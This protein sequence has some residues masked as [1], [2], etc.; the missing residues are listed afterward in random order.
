MWNYL[1]T[2]IFIG[3]LTA[4]VVIVYIFMTTYASF[5]VTNETLTENPTLAF[6]K[7]TDHN[8]TVRADTISRENFL[9]FVLI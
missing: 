7:N 6:Y 3:L 2:F 5:T 9:I 1:M 8:A 4:G